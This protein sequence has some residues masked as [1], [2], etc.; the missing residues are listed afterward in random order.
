[1]PFTTSHPAVVLLL[2]NIFPKYLSL[3]GLI[4]G[5]MA[6]DLLYFL[7][8]NTVN[9]GMSHSWSGMF[10][11]C[12]PLG[13]LFSFA[14]H[15]FFKKELIGHLPSPLLSHFSGL[16]LSKWRIVSFTNWIVLIISVLIGTLSHFAWDSCTHLHGEVV[17]YFP[18]LQTNLAIFGGH[19]QFYHLLQHLSTLVGGIAVI[20]YFSYQSNLPKRIEIKNPIPRIQK[21][22]FWITIPFLSGIFAYLVLHLYIYYAPERIASERTIF[23]LASWAGFFYLVIALDLFKRFRKLSRISTT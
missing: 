15:Y 23:G 1:M 19:I 2:K 20:I 3:T 8:M 10:T 21:L 9:R 13:I 22:F 18:V 5:A 4:A 11:I 14:F 17:Q 7:E 16:A 12:L 6:P